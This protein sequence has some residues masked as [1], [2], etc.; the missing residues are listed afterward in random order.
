MKDR[1]CNRTI[2]LVLAILMIG[3][4]V[5]L[6]VFAEA[7]SD[8]MTSK[9]EQ[10]QEENVQL[11]TLTINYYLDSPD[12]NMI[13]APYIAQQVAGTEYSVDSPEIPNFKLKDSSQAKISGTLTQDT[14]ISVCYTYLTETYPYTVIYEGFDPSTNQTIT[15]D[16]VTGYAPA[17]TKV[18]VEYR[19]FA[20][21]DKDS[22][23]KMSLVVTA[24][25]KASKT[26]R[27]TRTDDIYIIFRTQGSYIA[28]I[29]R[30]VGTDIRSEINNIKNPT[31]EGYIFAGWEYNGTV[32]QSAT[33]LA[34]AL[35]TMPLVQTYVDAVWEPGVAKYTILTWFQNAD[36]DNYT[37]Y[38]N[39]ETRSGYVGVTVTASPADT[40]KGDNN[41]NDINNPYFGFD[42]AYCEDTVIKADGTAVLNLYFDREI[43]KINYMEETSGGEI[44]RTIE[45]KYMS[46]I[47]DKLISREEL[48]EHYGPSFAY[49]A[50]TKKGNDSAMLER[51]ENSK[52]GTTE[53]GE[54]NIFPYLDKNI[55]EFQIRQFSYDPNADYK[56]LVLIKT[57]YIYYNNYYAPGMNLFPPEGF[58]WDGG[59]WRT[60]TTESGLESASMETNPN[61]KGQ[62]G[63][64]TFWGPIFQYMD[65]Y[66]ERDKSLLKYVSNDE[67]V[68]QISNVP[69]EKNLDLSVVPESGAE[70][71]Q[72]AGWYI[73]PSLMNLIEPLSE[74]QMPDSDLTL[75]AKW[76]PVNHTV[77]FDSQG[78]TAVDSQ[79]VMH[80][81]TAAEPEPPKREGYAF[82]GWYTEKVG[83]DLWSFDRSVGEDV[84]LYAHWRESGTG[85]FTINHVIEGENEPFY[86]KNGISKIG[87]TVYASPL[88]PLDDNY[89]DDVYVE[90]LSAASKSVVVTKGEENSVTFYYKKIGQRSYTVLYKDKKTGQSLTDSK[91]VSTQNTVITELPVAIPDYA[92]D[93]RYQT[94]TLNPSGE[95]II[96]FY[97]TTT[98]AFLRIDKVISGDPTDV[99][100]SGFSFQIKDES[101]GK[102]WYM[103]VDGTGDA[104]MDGTVGQLKLDPGEYTVTE[105]DNINYTFVSVSAEKDGVPEGEA[106]LAN[107]GITVTVSGNEIT[108]VTFTNTCKDGPGVTDGSSVINHFSEKDEVIT[109]EPVW[110]ANDKDEPSLVQSG[111]IQ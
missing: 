41:E 52:S 100:Y 50:K 1:I 26:L 14:E 86:Q 72:F 17:G 48:K 69:Y 9:Q 111:G 78:G 42:Y 102:V 19:E 71:M 109:F 49:M 3:Y 59:R 104:T 93:T 11:V 80:N 66:M 37:L 36:D 85:S 5:P 8:M 106:D 73:D 33:E 30:D 57:S 99:T 39:T 81:A 87:D 4:L 2:A 10:L 32:Y 51:F 44:W 101:T 79:S 38:T 27:Y 88:S 68:Q 22:V 76:V 21:Y 25:G 58:L 89:P 47:G 70:Y 31:R 34:G 40:A 63:M 62:D 6:N 90:P 60:A 83:G 54:Q 91:T 16:T 13:Y 64:A 45:G 98:K 74:Y 96:T 53:Y 105:L 75:Y 7:A 65:I 84:T 43:W 12:G 107:H 29:T 108:T 23:D 15:L 61:G 110:I 77:T 67:I 56:D 103:H 97:Y 82:T 35:S 94:V 46:S 95:N 55:Y 18:S 92:C 20:G 24:D 28:P